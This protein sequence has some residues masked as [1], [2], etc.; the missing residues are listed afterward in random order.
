MLTCEQ[1]TA[2]AG[3]MVDGELSFHEQIAV[4]MHMMMCV[5]CRRFARQLRILVSS[6]PS[7]ND[8]DTKACASEF[9]DR[10]MLIRDGADAPLSEPQKENAE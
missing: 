4:R 7:R 9:T 3:L 10:V 1:V 2:K 6:M 5:K 8:T